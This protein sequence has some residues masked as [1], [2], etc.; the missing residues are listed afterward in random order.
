MP[1]VTKPSTK[2]QE[3]LTVQCYL[4]DK[5]SIC[6]LCGNNFQNKYLLTKIIHDDLF[7][8]SE[9]QL[10]IIQVFMNVIQVRQKL[11]TQKDLGVPTT[12]NSGPSG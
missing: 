1:D 10:I 7:Q 5:Q 9:K 4:E 2:A 11:R 3:T 12:T 6:T 8:N